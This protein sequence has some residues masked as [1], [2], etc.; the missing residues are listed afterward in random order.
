MTTLKKKSK[1]KS[2]PRPPNLPTAESSKSFWTH[3]DKATW[4]GTIVTGIGIFG[5]LIF[6]ALS[7]K[8]ATNQRRASYQPDLVITHTLVNLKVTCANNRA[9]EKVDIQYSSD[10]KNW[11]SAPFKLQ[12]INVGK[13]AARDIGY[14][15]NAGTKE[16]L[17]KLKSYGIESP[18]GATGLQYNGTVFPYYTPDTIV[19][20]DFVLTPDQGKTSELVPSPYLNVELIFQTVAY[21]N[22]F[23]CSG[24]S[25][26]PPLKGPI[27][28]IQ[29]H[30]IER[31]Y[32][33]AEF[34]ANYFPYAAIKSDIAKDGSGTLLLPYEI[35]MARRGE[36]SHQA[37]WQEPING[38]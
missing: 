21:I 37:A 12:V 34:E 35:R 38:L 5:A 17:D 8:E 15:W 3:S 13:G 1:E 11:S 28:D 10:L 14:L 29:Y 27:L 31:N 30:D 16:Q 26:H 6:N 4:V 20:Q 2:P 24:F 23:G 36:R 33:H 18:N 19:N 22:K 32:F 7:L 25:N 9:E